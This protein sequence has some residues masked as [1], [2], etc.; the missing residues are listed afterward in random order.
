MATLLQFKSAALSYILFKQPDAAK[1]KTFEV[2][3]RSGGKRTIHAPIDALKLMQKKLSV[4]LQN[5]LDEINTAKN[6]QNRVSHGF[7]RKRSIV[8]N[9]RQHRNRRYV[10]NLDLEDFFPSIHFGRVRGFFIKDRNFAL[11]KDVATVIAQIAS[12]EKTAT[13]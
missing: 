2:P 12:R 4:L 9:A 1:Y 3:K 7:M 5:C 10:F 13:R 11:H 8:T 6:L